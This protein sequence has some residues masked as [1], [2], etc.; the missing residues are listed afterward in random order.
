MTD[1]VYE[2]VY[3]L[4]A[5][6]DK[7]VAVHMGETAGP[8]AYLKYAHPLT[9]DEAAVKHPQIVEDDRLLNKT[10]AYRKSLA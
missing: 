1:A 3:E 9:L 8:S 10:L 5:A 6:Y 4:A 7:P 2:P